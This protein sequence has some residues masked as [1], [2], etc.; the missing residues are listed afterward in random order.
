M[1]DSCFFLSWCTQEWSRCAGSRIE[2][3]A[4][5]RENVIFVELKAI[6]KIKERACAR[7]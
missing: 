6:R 1:M 2:L 7:R 4:E 3:I 5:P